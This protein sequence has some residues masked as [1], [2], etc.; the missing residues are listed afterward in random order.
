MTAW[1]KVN[2]NL[3]VW[4]KDPRITIRIYNGGGFYGAD[5]WVDYGLTNEAFTSIDAMQRK[6][7]LVYTIEELISEIGDRDM[8]AV[9]RERYFKEY[10]REYE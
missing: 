1:K 6:G 7:D 4:N 2:S 8:W 5:I 9:F 10:H 3:W